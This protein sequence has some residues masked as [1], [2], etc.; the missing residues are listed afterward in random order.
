MKK[1]VFLFL[2]IAALT[3]A[4]CACGGSSVDTGKQYEYN[5]NPIFRDECDEDMKID[6]VLDE[7]RWQGKNVFSHVTRGIEIRTTATLTDKGAYIAAVAYDPSITWYGRLDMRN[8]SCFQIY[9][10]LDDAE[11]AKPFDA[12]RFD[13]DSKNIRSYN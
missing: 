3:I 2:I 12:L 1:R 4:V 6:G 11:K 13:V 9:V 5:Y 8:N 10:A 7:E